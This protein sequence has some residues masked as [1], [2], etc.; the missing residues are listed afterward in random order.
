MSRIF[1]V[2][3]HT[4]PNGKAY[5]GITS[6]KPATRW[7]NGRG[8]SQN[9]L[10]YR[11]INKYGWE[12]FKHEILFTGLT[13]EQAEKKEMELIKLYD[14]TDPTK[15]YNIQYGGAVAG[16]MTEAQ[17]E[18]IRARQSGALSRW[19]GKPAY[20]RGIP[21]TEEQRK[22]TS[23]ARKG[24]GGGERNANYKR[25]YTEEEKL[26]LS[27]YRKGKTDSE[28]T[29]AKKSKAQREL[30]RTDNKPVINRSTGEVYSSRGEASRATGT[31]PHSIEKCCKGQRKRAGGCIWSFYIEGESY[32]LIKEEQQKQTKKTPQRHHTEETIQKIRDARAKQTPPRGKA[33]VCIETGK[34]YRT[35][36]EAGIDTEC[37][38]SSIRRVCKGEY[39]HTKGL[40]FAFAEQEITV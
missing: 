37:D 13:Q 3:R 27:S 7:Q 16:T 22:K 39:A 21:A 28:E 34:T 18:R 19:Y 12:S 30:E 25:Q 17:R 26:L 10:F 24:K 8:Y 9:K 38:S 29:K 14:L 4:A 5:I 33:I 36:V 2:Y 6:Q 32:P 23:E 11:A 40:H 20:N 1:T 35:A 31:N 15:G